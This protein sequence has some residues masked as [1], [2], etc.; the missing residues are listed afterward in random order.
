MQLQISERSALVNQASLAAMHTAIE[1]LTERFSD[2]QRKATE[3]KI[4]LLVEAEQAPVLGGRV[5]FRDDLAS[6]LES[7]FV[8]MPTGTHW[9]RSIYDAV[10]HAAREAGLRTH[11]ADMMVSAGPIIDQIFES[12]AK[13]G[14]VLAD[15]T[16]RNPNVMYELGLAMAMK[17]KTLL[18]AQEIG[19]VPFD[20][21]HQRVLLYRVGAIDALVHQLLGAF[22]LHRAEQAASLASA[23]LPP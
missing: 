1:R 5:V 4:Q 16:N 3:E 8:L 21:R 11:R 18:I 20:V 12:I 9:D 2:S 15:L 13:S 14:L 7:V 22:R 23:K 19:D 10:G 17:K 6:D